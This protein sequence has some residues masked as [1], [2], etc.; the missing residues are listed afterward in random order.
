MKQ[1][2]VADWLSVLRQPAPHLKAEDPEN[3]AT[4][5]NETRQKAISKIREIPTSA[6]SMP[7]ENSTFLAQQ[8]NC[9]AKG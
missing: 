9:L 2:G 3:G 1:Q 5:G 8:E 4:W 7:N 6:V